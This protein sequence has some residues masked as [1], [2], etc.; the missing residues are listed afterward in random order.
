MGEIKYSFKIKNAEIKGDEIAVYASFYADD[1]LVKEIIHGFQKTMSEEEIRGEIQKAL[2]LY[3]TE[4]DQAER[5][6]LVDE[7]T[8]KDKNLINNLIG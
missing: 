3:V 4:L 2:D 1:E 6:K 5:Q 8:E 7:E